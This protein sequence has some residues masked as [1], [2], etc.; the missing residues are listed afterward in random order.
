VAD[1]TTAVTTEQQTRPAGAHHRVGRALRTLLG[2]LWTTT[3][4]DPVRE[5]RL[6]LDGL[7]GPERQLARAGLV[8]LVLLLVSLLFIDRWREG[9]LLLL[10]GTTRARFV[11]EALLPVTVAA[12]FLALVLIVWGALDAA[13]SVR[14]LVAVT[15]GGTVGVLQATSLGTDDSWIGLHG[16]T[17]IRVGYVVPFAALL[18]S[19]LLAPVTRLTRWLTP[20]LR[21]LC[22]LAFVAMAGSLLWMDAGTADAG[23]GR[24]VPLSLYQG[25]VLIDGLL[26]PLTIV[27][28]VAVVDFASD[29]SSSLA[30][31]ATRSR[32]RLVWLVRG[33]LVTLIAVKLWLD[34]VDDRDYWRAYLDRQPA[35]V[36][37]TVVA[38]ALLL[39]SCVVVNRLARPSADHAVDE[40]KER[41]TLGGAVL[42]SLVL[43]VNAF[44]LGLGQ[45]SFTFTGDTRLAD[46]AK[47]FPTD[48]ASTW[49][50]LVASCL[51]VAAGARLLVRARTRAVRPYVLELATG[52]VVLGLW[53]T[54]EGLLLVADVSWGFS[55]RA[56]DVLVT[57]GVLVWAAVRWRRLDAARTSLLLAL[58][59][60]SWLVMSR[61]D[62]ISFLGGLLGLPTVVVVVF[63]IAYTLASGAGFTTESSPR[64]P[65]EAR[66]LIFTGYLLLSVSIL[67]WLEAAHEAS[68]EIGIV[69]FRYVAIPL[70]AW[71]VAR[72]L[73]PRS[74][75]AEA[76]TDPPPSGE[77]AAGPRSAP[78]VAP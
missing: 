42:F 3:F 55:S 66:T 26:V 50:A 19:A 68:E 14:L 31:P 61:G 8:T 59:L 2:P 6:R 58:V 33:A 39:V 9:S 5:G 11:P 28:A 25:F 30:E 41:L 18:V 13:P 77:A 44:L 75:Q 4:R 40:A 15:Y 32:G 27:A 72:R 16:T 76:P 52:L 46:V 67:H 49:V 62:Y 54:Q 57:L 1:S 53:N 64:L 47:G 48:G 35:S 73:V 45:V 20:V 38:I 24:L 21:A 69:G 74:G 34:V 51:A 29:V 22:L 43:V 65:R 12:F 71:L 78:T 63:G 36:V 37:R 56:V 17:V 23:F 7:S 70:A 10:D 60:F